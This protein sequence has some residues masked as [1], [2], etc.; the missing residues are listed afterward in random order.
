MAGETMSEAEKR[1]HLREVVANFDTAMLVTRSLQGEMRARPL[2]LAA[3]PE[4]PGDSRIYFPTSAQSLKVHEIEAD[5]R[6]S[7]TMQDARR[8]V[9]LSGHAGI[10][11]DRALIDRM[12]SES[13]KVWFPNGKDDP[14]LCLLVVTP[15]SAEYW[16]NTGN[17]GL[18]YLFEA[19]K[20]YVQGRRAEETSDEH[21]AKVPL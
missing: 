2:A 17:K 14:L 5:P 16:D 4:Q 21:N 6:V 18:G 3:H 1:A 9:S 20:A 7:I 11:Q 10:T 12:W 15:T 8:F 19:A 13:W